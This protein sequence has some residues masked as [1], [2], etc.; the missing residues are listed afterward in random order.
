MTLPS[1][2]LSRLRT[3]EDELARLLILDVHEIFSTMIGME[4]RK[5]VPVPIDPKNLFKDSITAMVG[6]VGT[7]SGI[8][9]LHLSKPL[10]CKITSRILDMTV[11][12]VNENVLDAVGEIANMIT[13]SF[14]LHLS[15]GGSDIRI[16]TPSLVT[17]DEYIISLFGTHDTLTLLYDIDKEWLMVAVAIE[18]EQDVQAAPA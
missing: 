15:P 17:G 9:S 4:D 6:L 14:K 5:N 1:A 3:T 13:G 7:Y 18:R 8:V 2:M 12:E 16:S 11:T 10:A